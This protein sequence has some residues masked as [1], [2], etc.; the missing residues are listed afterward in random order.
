APF[1]KRHRETCPTRSCPGPLC[2]FHAIPVFLGYFLHNFSN[3]PLAAILNLAL[4]SASKKVSFEIRLG[5]LSFG[6]ARRG[7]VPPEAGRDL[8]RPCQTWS[9]RPA[10]T[11][12]ARK[13][14]RLQTTFPIPT[15]RSSLVT[16]RQRILE[17]RM[18]HMTRSPRPPPMMAS[19][20]V[21]PK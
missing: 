6:F 4:E 17:E 10:T 9:T 3:T 7:V 1:H 14:P 11:M 12:T 20:D 5:P 13:P 21:P 15:P 18:E 8:V 16:C 19:V 2:T